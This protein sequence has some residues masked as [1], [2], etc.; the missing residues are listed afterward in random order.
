MLN[1]NMTEAVSALKLFWFSIV[2]VA[3]GVQSLDPQALA[4]LIAIFA[5]VARALHE[6]TSCTCRLLL[7]RVLMSSVIG[8]ILWNFC[9]SYTLDVGK[10]VAITGAGALAAPEL[11]SL[12]IFWIKKQV[13]WFG[14]L[15]E[16]RSERN[17]DD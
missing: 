14:G 2:T 17:D 6:D 12:V 10:K 8:F 5:G 15:G 4:I 11:L 16:N 13:R 3:L 7:S 9:D 1:E